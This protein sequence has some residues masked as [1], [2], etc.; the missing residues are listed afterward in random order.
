VLSPDLSRHPPR[1][2]IEG[3]VARCRQVQAHVGLDHRV[4]D[5]ET[6]RCS[7]TAG[8]VALARAHQSLEGL[9][10]RRQGPRQR[11]SQDD[12]GRF[13]VLLVEARP[14]VWAEAELAVPALLRRQFGASDRAAAHPLRPGAM[15]IQQDGPS[16][17]T[18]GL[19]MLLTTLAPP[20][21]AAAARFLAD[22]SWTLAFLAP[23]VVFFFVVFSS[24]PPPWSDAEYIQS[25]PTRQGPTVPEQFSWTR[26]RYWLDV[27]QS[28]F[29]SAGPRENEE[30]TLPSPMSA[31]RPGASS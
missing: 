7:T 11:M 2:G 18:F 27:E 30:L 22:R 17:L 13:P 19:T 20:F 4:L 26:T 12:A 21:A 29:Q 28:T 6:H 24:W 14:E 1:E 8:A 31:E 25:S 5:A 9:R 16:R 23:F 3:G 15:S 10:R